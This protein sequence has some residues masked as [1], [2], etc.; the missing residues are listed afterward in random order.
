MG[1]SDARVVAGT[2]AIAVHLHEAG[3]GLLV[4]LRPTDPSLATL[5]VDRQALLLKVV[6]FWE[7]EGVVVM[8]IQSLLL[9][10][11]P[12][13]LPRRGKRLIAILTSSLL[14]D[15]EVNF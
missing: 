2:L 3:L 9:R 10:S 11:F 12:P 4:D 6:V 8:V 14:P 5:A 15:E 1:P 13:R 7:R